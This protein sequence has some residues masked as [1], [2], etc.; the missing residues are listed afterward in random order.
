MHNEM[1]ISFQDNHC[2]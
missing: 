1:T 2:W